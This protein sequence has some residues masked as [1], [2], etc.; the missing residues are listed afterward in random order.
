MRQVVI[1][2]E[3]TGPELS[4]GHRVI[5]IGGVEL[6][7]E[8]LSGRHYHQYINPEKP[9]E[10]VTIDRDG[11]TNEFLADKP[12][13]SEI[14]QEF[15]DFVG[16]DE[17]VTYNA[18][19][20]LSFLYHEFSLIDEKVYDDGLKN[21][22]VDVLLI[23]N[24]RHPKQNNSLHNLCDRYYVDTSQSELYGS[25][26]R[27]EIIADLLMALIDESTKKSHLI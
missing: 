2:I 21:D 14:A 10:E 23:G 5:E 1:S 27:A 15:Q 8:K 25:L 7:D 16:A 26:L 12:I 20:V 9:V 17:V 24:E 11:I 4:S 22:V 3:T 19:F 13:F 6:I 18:G